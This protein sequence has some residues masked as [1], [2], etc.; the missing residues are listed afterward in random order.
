[1]IIDIRGNGGGTVLI[2]RNL[3]RYIYTKPILTEGGMVLATEDNIKDGYSTEY[4]QISDSMKL[5][6]KKN[7]AKLESHKGE[8]FN[9]YPI[10]TIKF[11]SILKNPQHISILADGNT[12][13]AAELFCYKLDKARKL[14]YLEKILRGPLII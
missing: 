11:E 4:P 9:L 6:F 10:D 2:F 14:N 8:L 1:L 12:G 7:L 13:S 3:M 5:V